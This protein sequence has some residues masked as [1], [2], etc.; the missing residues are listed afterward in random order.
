MSGFTLS[1]E[2]RESR[3]L[4]Q[5]FSNEYQGESNISKLFTC[6]KVTPPPPPTLHP[7][8][9]YLQSG[10]P[11]HPGSPSYPNKPQHP[12]RCW[13]LP[14][15]GNSGRWKLWWLLV[16]SKVNKV[17]TSLL[18][19]SHPVPK[20]NCD[21]FVPCD[22]SLLFVKK[23]S[24]LEWLSIKCDP[25]TTGNFSPYKRARVASCYTNGRIMVKY[26][27]SKYIPQ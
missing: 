24:R 17:F 11:L 15:I 5:Q 20:A 6:E 1:V 25:P 21:F 3:Y 10:R 8:S 18:F 19:T 14:D 23:C 2:K 26:L 16:Q 13:S 12:S 4:F 9:P 27:I 22:T 7:G